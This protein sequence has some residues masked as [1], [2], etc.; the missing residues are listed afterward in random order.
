M[1]IRRLPHRT[2]RI[3]PFALYQLAGCLGL[4]APSWGLVLLPT[5]AFLRPGWWT[6][7]WVGWSLI[8]RAGPFTLTVWRP[9]PHALA[10]ST[11][12]RC[13]LETCHEGF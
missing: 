11:G 9:V 2:V 13:C 4:R 5:L 1:T 10:C 7:R 12:N 6:W 8:I 3:G